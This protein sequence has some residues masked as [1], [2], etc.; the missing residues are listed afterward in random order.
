MLPHV[1]VGWPHQGGGGWACITLCLLFQFILGGTPF[2]VNPVRK[3]GFRAAGVDRL[4][5][6]SEDSAG[7]KQGQ[8]TWRG[9]VPSACRRT[10]SGCGWGPCC[11]WCGSARTRKAQ[12]CGHG[13][14]PRG[15]C[16]H[17]LGTGRRPPASLES[18]VMSWSPCHW[19]RWADQC[20]QGGEK[21]ACPSWAWASPRVWV[22]CPALEDLAAG[23]MGVL[24][25]KETLW[26]EYRH[27]TG[28]P[29]LW[30]GTPLLCPARFLSIP[31]VYWPTPSSASPRLPGDDRTYDALQQP[32]CLW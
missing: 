5:R 14:S 29:Q 32:T 1:G 28:H 13:L 20:L 21:V 25:S 18:A 12:R 4:H 10:W 6:A 27:L 26:P 23:C 30:P 31:Q 11:G 8:G 17:T 3:R 7:A 2:Q 15:P 22:C 9:H 16:G 19:W 24:E